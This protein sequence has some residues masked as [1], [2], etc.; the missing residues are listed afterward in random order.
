MPV[1][2]PQHVLCIVGP[3]GVGKTAIG[4]QLAKTLNGEIISADSR[5]MYRFM[6]IGTDKPPSD[7]IKQIP[8]YFIDTLDPDESYNAGQFGKQAR[9]IINEIF[10]RGKLPIV[11]G[12]SGLYIKSLLE[13]FFDETI[14]NIEVKRELQREINEKGSEALYREL[15]NADPEFAASISVNDA[16]RITRGLEVFRATG[17]PLSEHWRESKI[18]VNFKSVVIGLKRDRE[19]LY[20]IINKRVDRMIELGLVDEVRTLIK[21]GYSK[22]LNSLKTYGY[23]EV[24]EY[25]DNNCSNDE[26]IEEIKKR[27]RN[28][29]KRQLTWFRKL[30][31]IIWISV[32]ENPECTAKSIMEIYKRKTAEVY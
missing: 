18:H 22:N 4:F 30:K 6:N 12:G 31:D 5:Q 11:V 13:G 32:G 8:H 17:K 19:E 23:Q 28:F 7:Y 1:H 25:L 10:A 16:Q 2:H 21:K 27:T 29:A 24:F 26:M 20:N 14:K 9:N 3:T 15:E